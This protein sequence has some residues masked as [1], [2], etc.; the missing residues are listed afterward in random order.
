VSSAQQED[1]LQE[2]VGAF[3]FHSPYICRNSG[4]NLRTSLSPR[5]PAHV[6]KTSE[7]NNRK[8]FGHSEYKISSKIFKHPIHIL[9][10]M[11]MK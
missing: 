3:V 2:I 10:G 11:E 5:L 8:Y 7:H 1:G 4:C 9:G 6:G